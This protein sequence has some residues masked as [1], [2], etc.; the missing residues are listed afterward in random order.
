MLSHLTDNLSYYIPSRFDEGYGLNNEAIDAVKADGAGL[1]VTVDC[2][3]VSYAEAEHAKAIGDAT[4][5]NG[6]ST[7]LQ[8][9][10]QTV[11]L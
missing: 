2:G 11:Y 3:S 1:I 6:S 5:S 7:A 9:E 10:E 8:T 4:H